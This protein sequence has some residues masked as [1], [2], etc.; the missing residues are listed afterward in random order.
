MREPVLKHAIFRDLSNDQFMLIGDVHND[1]RF[2]D[3]TMIAT[4]NVTSVYKEDGKLYAMT[5]NTRYVIDED[6]AVTIPGVKN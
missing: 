3:G 5:R 4:S 1:K 2:E 6:T